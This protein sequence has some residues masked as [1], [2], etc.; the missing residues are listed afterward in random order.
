MKKLFFTAL[1]ACFA[2]VSFA[3]DVAKEMK[4]KSYDEANAILQQNF[5]TL[6][7]EQ[8]AKAYATLTDIAYGPANDLYTAIQTAAVTGKQPENPDYTH[9]VKAINA[10]V[11]CDKY[12]NMPNDKGKVAPKF[13]KKNAD[14][15][16][17]FRVMLINP[18]NETKDDD[19]KLMYANCY[20][21]SSSSP[22]FAESPSVKDGD[23][24]VGYAEFFSAVAYYNKKDWSNVTIHAQNAMSNPDVKDQSE[25]FLISA[26]T[27]NLHSRSDSL[28]YIAV[29]SKINPEKYLPSIASM[30]SALG[31]TE[32]AE[33]MLNNAIA[34]NPQNKMA[35]A[36]KGENAMNQK[37]WDEAIENFKKC[38]D[39]DPSF[40]AVWFNLGVCASSKGF[41][42]NEKLSN[43]GRISKENAEKVNEVLKESVTYYEKVRALDPNH[44][45][46]TQWPMQLRMLYNAL[47]ETAKAQEITDMLGY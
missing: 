27:N 20:L 39:I 31:E 40:T 43:N 11:E 9:F 32:K 6:T 2:T 16:D 30:Y 13:H 19:L 36:I 10:A 28:N 34:A 25:Q 33:T 44:E 5:A 46:I 12:D 47:G 15:L 7:A 45:Q 23:K 26:L 4:G 38:V 14:R 17:G 3:Q 22:L 24:Y 8:K 29:L 37:K 41:D 42:M 1:V 21:N 35:Y 18:A